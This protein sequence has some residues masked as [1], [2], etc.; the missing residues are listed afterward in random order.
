MKGT[1]DTYPASLL[2]IGLQYISATHTI[3]SC[4][5]NAVNNKKSWMHKVYHYPQTTCINNGKQIFQFMYSHHGQS[6]GQMISKRFLVASDSSKK[7]TNEFGFFGLTVLKTNLFVRFFG[8]IRGYQKV[9][10]KLSDL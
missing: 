6:K 2:C 1:S 7:R 8:R 5:Y 10:L 9:L 4:Y 3:Q